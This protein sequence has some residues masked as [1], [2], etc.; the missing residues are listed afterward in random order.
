MA[1]IHFYFVI[2]RHQENILFVIVEFLENS[3]G[4]DSRLKHIYRVAKFHKSNS[5]SLASVVCMFTRNAELGICCSRSTNQLNRDDGRL[6][7][8]PGGGS[9]EAYLQRSPLGAVV[10]CRFYL[11]CATF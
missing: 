11:K 2:S 3:A 9:G 8:Q 7:W 1:D 4:V 5:F 10:L 6:A